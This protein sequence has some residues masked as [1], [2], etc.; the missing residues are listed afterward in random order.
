MVGFAEYA[1]IG[2]QTNLF[3]EKDGNF[4]PANNVRKDRRMRSRNY[5]DR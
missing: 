2:V 1:G 5:Q 4:I 3:Q